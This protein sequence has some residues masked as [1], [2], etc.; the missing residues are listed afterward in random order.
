ME[1]FNRS[2]SRNT[3]TLDILNSH[4]L[5]SPRNSSARNL[6]IQISAVPVG[7]AQPIHSHE[8]EQ[9]YYII[10][11]KGLMTIEEETREAHPGDA[12]S[13]FGKVRIPVMSLNGDLWPVNYEGNR[14]HM[15]SFD[16]IVLRKADHFLMM[17]RPEEFNRALE[18]AIGKLSKP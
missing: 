11:G 18:K 3:G 5:I 16:A 13:I 12:A 7:S 4:M 17:D 15:L 8:P 1:V 14:R 6:S 9:C 2:N 10:A